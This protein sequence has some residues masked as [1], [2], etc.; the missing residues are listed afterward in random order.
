MPLHA[1]EDLSQLAWAL[2]KARHPDTLFFA[3]VARSMLRLCP[4]P[5]PRG[6]LASDL[7]PHTNAV[8]GAHLSFKERRQLLKLRQQTAP[9]VAMLPPPQPAQGQGGA[10]APPSRGTPS[11]PMSA[12]L[13]A[14]S[15]DASMEGGPVL[16]LPGATSG[17]ANTGSAVTALGG[18]SQGLLERQNSEDLE[19]ALA[20]YGLSGSAARRAAKVG[21]GVR[22]AHCL[23]SVHVTQR[24]TILHAPDPHVFLWLLALA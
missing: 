17:S 5:P 14:S 3:S 24:S 19:R 13:P 22:C 23:L 1:G 6:G 12:F 4:P 20:L 18:L 9:A 8:L 2:A 10:G 16:A 21:G 15:A 7:S 11:D